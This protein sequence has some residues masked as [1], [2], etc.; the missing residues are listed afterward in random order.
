MKIPS[1]GRTAYEAYCDELDWKSG[2]TGAPLPSYED[3]DGKI[4][5][6]WEAAASK[7]LEVFNW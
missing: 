3:Q 5:A 4:I 6:A 2:I 1:P 7:V